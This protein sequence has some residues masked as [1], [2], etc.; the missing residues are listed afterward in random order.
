MKLILILVGDVYGDPL[1]DVIFADSGA[2]TPGP[3]RSVSEFHDYFTLSFGPKARE[4][5]EGRTPHPYRSEL[6]DDVPIVFTHADLHPSNIIVSPREA[7]SPRVVSVIDWQQSGWYPAYWEYC[8]AC[9]TA[10]VGGPWAEKYL[11]LIVD[12]E[13][14]PYWDYF[15]LAYGM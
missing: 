7:G 9:W 10:K 14:Y 4:P 3:F 5:R 6:P 1:L 12:V 15:V 8:K 13:C 11:P 2:P